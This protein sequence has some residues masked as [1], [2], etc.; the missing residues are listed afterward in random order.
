M[1]RFLSNTLVM[2]KTSKIRQ[3][4]RLK[5]CQVRIPGIC[6][7]DDTE[8]ILAHKNGAGMAMKS[9]DSHGAYCCH[10][11]HAEIDSIYGNR[12]SEFSDDEILIMFYEGI[13]RTQLILIEENLIIVKS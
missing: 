12:K 13:F 6:S 4:A 10:N 3:S 8:T 1:I 11:C 5:E 2:P 9:N 7:F